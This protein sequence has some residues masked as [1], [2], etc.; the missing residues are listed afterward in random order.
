M[1]TSVHTHV[2]MGL[3]RPEVDVGKLSLLLSTLLTEVTSSYM[4]NLTSHVALSLPS[5]VG[6]VAT[7]PTCHSPGFWVSELQPSQASDLNC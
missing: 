7:M 1:R 4:A 2:C 5:N 6:I 3:L